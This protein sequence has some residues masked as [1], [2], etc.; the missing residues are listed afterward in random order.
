MYASIYTMDTR[1]AFAMLTR[2][3]ANSS[4]KVRDLAARIGQGAGDDAKWRQ[5]R[6]TAGHT[7]DG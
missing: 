4:V 2:M 1:H 7:A 5:R 6:D 3:S